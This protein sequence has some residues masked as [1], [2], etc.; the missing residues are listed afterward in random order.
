MRIGV[1]V[2]G[3]NTD[4]VLMVGKNIISSF[5]SPTTLDITQGVVNAV[6]FL[7][8]DAQIEAD[9]IDSVMI[10]TT[11]FTNALVERRH[12]SPVAILRLATPSGTSIPPLTG[13]PK[14]LS[15]LMGNH[16]YELPGGYEIDG[17]EISAFDASKVRAAARD[18]AQ[19]GL[20]AVAISS[21]HA[22]INAQMERVAADIIAQECPGVRITL[23]SEIGRV[24][25]LERENSA[26]INASCS[27]FA[28][29]VVR[30]F[31]KALQEIGISSP[32]Y[33]SQNDGTLINARTAERFPILTFASGPTNSIRGAAFLSGV[34][35]GLVMDIGGTTCD[36]GVLQNGFP[37]ESS[38]DVDVGGVR[39]NFRMPDVL[40]VGLGGGTVIHTPNRRL[41]QL[42]NDLSGVQLGPESVGFELA[43]KG[44]IF[45]GT[46]LTATDIAV[47]S[48][49]SL[50]IG[51]R[52]RLASLPNEFV[53]AVKAKMTDL[54][55][56]ALDR[57]KTEAGDVPV[58][59][60]GG[61]SILVNAN[62]PGSSQT[63]RPPFSSVANAVGAAI[64]QVSGEVD[65]VYCYQQLGRTEALKDAKRRAIE[66]A[67]RAGG[68]KDTIQVVELEEVPMAY[69]PGDAVRVKVKAVGDL[70]VAV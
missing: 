42:T 60:V 38:I 2:G 52:D 11:Q 12:L 50:T 45:G 44:L 6:N 18:I 68:I 47:A 14:D 69:V 57:M 70:G 63:I 58:I 54:C 41:E 8:D 33:I 51:C 27:S 35:N 21:A 10:G 64:A 49:P 48:D 4:A 20:D 3:T 37:R 16:I 65:K 59:L 15:T 28:L 9:R 43:E 61:G 62:L 31:G 5:K 7:L 23:S 32:F 13:W 34:D 17:R 56:D 24:G 1:D 53:A 46:T 40:A 39:T 66:S 67:V 22:T 25:L 55:A 26:I 36:I 30:S 19:K 29:K